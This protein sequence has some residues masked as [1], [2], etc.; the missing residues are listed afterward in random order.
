[1]GRQ[2]LEA[3]HPDDRDRMGKEW[4]QWMQTHKPGE[5]YKH[6]GRH[7]WPDGRITW[8]DSYVLPETNQESKI[9]G[10]IG[11]IVDITDRKEAEI[12]LQESERRY[13]T[14]AEAHQ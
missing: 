12:A 11:T 13:A 5:I 8:F 1:M 14:L 9:I 3:I 7:I 2:W 6:Q 4:A 10:Y